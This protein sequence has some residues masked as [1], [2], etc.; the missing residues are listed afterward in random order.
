MMTTPRI[1]LSRSNTVNTVN[2]TRVV[3]FLRFFIRSSFFQDRRLS[4]LLDKA[5]GAVSRG[6]RGISVDNGSI[7]AQTVGA[8]SSSDRL[9]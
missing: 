6:R 3:L 5:L 4:R 1:M 2:T 9:Q 8:K 7:I